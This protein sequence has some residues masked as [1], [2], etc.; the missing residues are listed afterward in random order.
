[1]GL[2]RRYDKACPIFNYSTRDAGV[3]FPFVLTDIIVV[4]NH[5]PVH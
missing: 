5:H 2:G 1:M 4:G 3:L